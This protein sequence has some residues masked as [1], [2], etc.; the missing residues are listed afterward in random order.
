MRES[1]VRFQPRS[2]FLSGLRL[3]ML[4]KG[5]MC[6]DNGK[7]CGTLPIELQKVRNALPTTQER[8]AY[9]S[10]AVLYQSLREQ[11]VFDAIHDQHKS[12]WF[13]YIK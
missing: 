11:C 2:L 4:F 5:L 3:P 12:H 10:R 6:I 1:I 7:Y 13:V 8:L 9:S